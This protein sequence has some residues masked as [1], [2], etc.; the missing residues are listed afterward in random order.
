M[1]FIEEDCLAKYQNYEEPDQ[2][3]YT[4]GKIEIDPIPAKQQ[5]SKAQQKYQ[6]EGSLRTKKGQE[7]SMLE[8]RY[9]KY[10]KNR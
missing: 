7:R 4:F 5:Y 6:V 10:V 8:D 2:R 1:E 3:K 9:N